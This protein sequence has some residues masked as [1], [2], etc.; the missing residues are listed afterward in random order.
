VLVVRVDWN[1][2]LDDRPGRD[3]FTVRVMAGTREVAQRTWK[4]NRPDAQTAT[5]RLTA[6]EARAFTKARNSGDAVVAVTQ[7]S[8]TNTDDDT[9]YERNN[10][11][12]VRVNRLLLGSGQQM[13]SDMI[14]TV[15][16][17]DLDTV[18]DCSHLALGPGADLSRCDLSGA[19]LSGADLSGA[20][21]TCANL[22]GTDLPPDLGNSTAIACYSTGSIGDSSGGA[23]SVWLCPT[24]PIPTT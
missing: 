7:Q 15:L 5:I 3:R 9:L 16:G 10:A 23:S 8:D 1:D 18:R 19:D 22:T 24:C 11:T 20:D 2:G 21:L 6:G 17:A 14:A 13:S 12:I 4:G